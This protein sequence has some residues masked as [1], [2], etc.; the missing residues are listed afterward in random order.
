MRWREGEG[1]QRR[2]RRESLTKERPKFS[3]TYKTGRI[4][5]V[6]RQA[7]SLPPPSGEYI[8]WQSPRRTSVHCP[9]LSNPRPFP[10]GPGPASD[11]S[12]K[13]LLAL[14]GVISANFLQAPAN[15][16]PAPP[17]P[18]QNPLYF[19]VICARVRVWVGP[20]VIRSQRRMMRAVPDRKRVSGATVCACLPLPH[21]HTS[22]F[23]ATSCPN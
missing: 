20:S 11:I 10:P 15:S 22:A 2:R 14:I 9:D 17:L 8:F 19:A 13:A 21:V 23:C 3:L 4:S 7:R 18:L 16:N 6:T 12:S 1:A 5:H